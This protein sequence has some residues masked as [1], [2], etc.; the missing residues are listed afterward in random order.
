MMNPYPLRKYGAILEKALFVA[1]SGL[2]IS[3]FCS[4]W[5]V[6][7]FSM[8]SIYILLAWRYLAGYELMRTLP[9]W[10]LLITALYLVSFTISALISE[11]KTSMVPALKDYRVLFLAGL[12]Y[13][14]PLNDR[15][16]K[17]IFIL[18]IISAIVGSLIG[19][20][21]YF[22]FLPNAMAGRPTG[23]AMHPVI[24][25]T[26]L[27]FACAVGILVLIFKEGNLLKS[28]KEL[29]L[30]LIMITVTWLGILYSQTRS[31]WLALLAAC[32]IS[33]F[34]YN[35]RKAAI[36]ILLSMAVMILVFA[37]SGPLR[38]RI[39]SLATSVSNPQ[40][41]SESTLTRLKLWKGAVLIFHE[42][43][44]F[45]TGLG[46]FNH[47][48]NRL[49]QTKQIDP[50]PDDSRGNAH[51]SFFHSLA[52]Q[53][54]V[55]IVTLLGLYGALI[56]FAARKIK[57]SGAIGGYIILSITIVLVVG[58]LTVPYLGGIGMG[59]I[60][61]EYCFIFGLLGSHGV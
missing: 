56:I 4:S 54:L 12:L 22:D 7:R 26:Q 43:P 60:I 21:Q 55:G 36:F 30:V 34:L 52:T 18:F 13:T 5:G 57:S 19:I 49:V 38:Q 9:K 45:G 40:S 31:M 44:M 37:S 51:S 39:V 47:D 17:Y 24:Y 25:A 59:V 53:G 28:K 50:M 27:A 29:F 61:T 11:D 3:F 46:D 1:L 42:S 2:A 20:L 6:S 48:I 14:A 23:S 16:R 33:L 58:G 35:R 32:S 41:D 15:Y 8:W 10:L